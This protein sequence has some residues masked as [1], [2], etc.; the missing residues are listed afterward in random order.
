MIYSIIIFDFIFGLHCF[1]KVTREGEV[2]VLRL[3][4][5]QPKFVQQFVAF[6]DEETPSKWYYVQIISR[7]RRLTVV[8]YPFISF[9]NIQPD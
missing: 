4:L 9:V 8:Q 1:R 3:A 5:D 6:V 7:V 2:P